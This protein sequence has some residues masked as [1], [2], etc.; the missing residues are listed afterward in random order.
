MRPGWL[1]AVLGAVGLFVW[2]R[3]THASQ[4]PPPGAA[5]GPTR[6]DNL[7][8]RRVAALGDSITAGDYASRLATLLPPGSI[9][10]AFGYP[11]QQVRPNEHQVSV[12]HHA[13][14]AIPVMDFARK[15]FDF[16]FVEGNETPG[17]LRV[18]WHKLQT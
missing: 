3:R 11:G 10:R 16:R 12:S 6:F 5:W 4:P 7:G 1:V 13:R 9:A 2:S 17:G 18:G 8:P 14:L 15:S